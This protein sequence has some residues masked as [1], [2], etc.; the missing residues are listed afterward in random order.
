MGFKD[1][2]E[3]A[4]FDGNMLSDIANKNHPHVVFLSKA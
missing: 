1:T 2:Q 4:R 3:I